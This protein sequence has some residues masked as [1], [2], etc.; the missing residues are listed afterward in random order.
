MYIQINLKELFNKTKILEF[1]ENPVVRV[2]S[3]HRKGHRFDPW[4]LRFHMYVAQLPT[5]ALINKKNRILCVKQACVTIYLTVIFWNILHGFLMHVIIWLRYAFS[6][7]PGYESW[8]IKKAEYW[9]TDAFKLQWYRR[10]LRVPWTAERSNQSIL[11]E[12]NPKYSLG[13][14]LLKLKLQYLG[15]LM[16]RADS[17]EKT[18]AGKD[19]RQKEK[20]AAED[21]MVGWHHWL[22]GHESEQTPGDSERQRSLAFYRPRGCKGSDM[23]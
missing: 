11:K 3:F 14:L 1:P 7:S 18:D 23:T 10:L 22:N 17:L 8:I 2:L 15:Y 21:E 13:G 4:K 20:G 5:A 9:R 19:W 12:I 16:R 6:S